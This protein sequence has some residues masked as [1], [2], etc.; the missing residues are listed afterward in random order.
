MQ[1]ASH[2]RNVGAR[3]HV[4]IGAAEQVAHCDQAHAFGAREGIV[5]DRG[6][7]RESIAREHR[8]D[9]A[10]CRQDCELDVDAL[11]LEITLVTRDVYGQEADVMHRLG[12]Q[13]FSRGDP[14]RH[15]GRDA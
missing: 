4:D 3:H 11:V 7:I 13:Q 6:N 5:I 1:V 14:L 12:K 2:W 10:P 15:S 9:E 8:I